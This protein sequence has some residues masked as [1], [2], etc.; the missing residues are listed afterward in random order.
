MRKSLGGVLVSGRL[1]ALVHALGDAGHDGGCEIEGGVER[2]FRDACAPG[3]RQASV[4]SRLT[5]PHD[6]DGQADELF[7]ALGEEV[8]LVGVAV[9][10]TEIGAIC[11]FSPFQVAGGAIAGL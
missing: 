1:I 9:E 6:G 8:H 10:L 5:I 3:V 11:H 4:H 7:L 2:L